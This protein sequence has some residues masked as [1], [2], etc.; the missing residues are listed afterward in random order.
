MGSIVT[1]RRDTDRQHPKLENPNMNPLGKVIKHGERASIQ[2]ERKLPYTPTQV[3]SAI[4]E[5]DELSCWFGSVMHE[6]RAG[7]AI[8]VIAGPDHVPIEA[9]RSVGRIVTWEPLK[10]FEYELIQK[11]VGSTTVRFELE[12]DG[13]STILRMTNQWLSLSNATGYA[14]GWHAFLDRLAAHLAKAPV[15]VWQARYG[16]VQGSYSWTA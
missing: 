1:L 14:P 7:G 9:R 13:E 2:F 3:W 10:V 4:T 12:P 6:A 8:T 16:E 5:T 15:P 11:L